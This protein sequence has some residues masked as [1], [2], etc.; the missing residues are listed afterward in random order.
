MIGERLDEILNKARDGAQAFLKSVADRPVAAP[1]EALPAVQFPALPDR[2]W[3]AQRALEHFRANLE[4]LLSGSAGP[5]YLGFVTGGST[6]AALAGDW[7]AAAYDQN[8]SSDGDSIATGVER[9]TLAMLRALFGVPDSF[10]GAFV[11]G[12]TQANVVALATARQWAYARLGIDVSEVGLTG[13]PPIS[14]LAG[15]PHASIDKAL[16]ILGM[17]RRCIERMALVEGRAAMDPAALDAHLR[18]RPA[19][20]PCIVSASAGEVNTGDFDDLR[21]VAEVAK[22]HGAWLHV[23]G[24]FGLFAAADPA[25]AH[26]VDGLELADSIA[27]DAHK[28][29]NVPYDSGFV[30]TRHLS[31]QERVFRAAGAYLGAGPDLLHRT[32]ENSRRFRALP[33]W[34]TL[35]AYGRE[36]YRD[37]VHRCCEHARRLGD[38]LRASRSYELL[39]DVHLNIVCFAPRSRDVRE[40]DRVLEAI[41]AGGRAFF[42]PTVYGGRPAI[43]AAF[44]NWSTTTE[45]VAIVARALDE[46]GAL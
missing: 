9:H 44:S 42:T 17:G 16:S 33:A 21:A 24:A 45:D 38:H 29:L 14:V 12:A 40:R 18:G 27:S 39:A 35:M 23:D 30:F 20:A 15:A 4:P 43:R 19:A 41:H 34:M 6:P 22:R 10:E 28:W 2:G 36:G 11:S 46:V 37:L 13:A 8:V 31:D 25:Y 1:R 5:R 26:L 3:G 7:L 32:P